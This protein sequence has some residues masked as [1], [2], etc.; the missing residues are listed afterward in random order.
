[1]NEALKSA[2]SFISLVKEMDADYNTQRDRGTMFELLSRTYLKNEPMYKRLFDDV[3]TLNEVP[4]EY[5]I[6]KTDTDVDLVAKERE[7][8]SLVAI[9]CKYYC[10]DTTIQKQHID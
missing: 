7:T 3:W 8:G 6:P 5:G 4:A 2:K 9:Q 1:M 10:E